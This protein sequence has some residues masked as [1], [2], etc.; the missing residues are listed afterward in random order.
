MSSWFSINIVI[1]KD[2]LINHLSNTCTDLQKG[3]MLKNNVLIYNI[4]EKEQE[5]T[6]QLT[7]EVFKSCDLSKKYNNFEKAHRKGIKIKGLLDQ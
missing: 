7:K 1:K 2:K 5:N 3:A 4:P 6:I